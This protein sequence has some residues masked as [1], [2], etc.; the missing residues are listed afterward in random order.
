MIFPLKP[1]FSSGVFHCDVWL[2][3]AIKNWRSK[4][5]PCVP[6]DRCLIDM[7]FFDSCMFFFSKIHSPFSWCNP[8]NVW[9]RSTCSF[10]RGWETHPVCSGRRYERFAEQRGW[11]FE[12]YD[13]PSSTKWWVGIHL[14]TGSTFVRY[15]S[16][17][18]FCYQYNCTNQLS[19]RFF[20][21]I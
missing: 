17:L 7:F 6:T 8:Y 19:I 15:F 11:Q 12:A 3:E 5:F 16:T 4:G 21:S 20:W 9:V 1:P 14:V 2:Q 18:I 13:F 10:P